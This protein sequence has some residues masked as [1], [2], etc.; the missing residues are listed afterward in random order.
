M[1]RLFIKDAAVVAPEGLLPRAWVLVEDGVI[2]AVSPGECPA[3]GD[4]RL[5]DAGGLTLVPG[6]IDLHIH[7]A[8]GYLFDDGP[9]A[10]QALSVLLP[11]HGVTGFL[12]AVTPCADDTGR[13]AALA[14]AKPKG[15]APVAFFLEGHFL[16]LSGSLSG[17]P[18]KHTAA[19]ARGLMAAAAPLGA[20]FAVSPEL[21][22]IMDILP[23]MTEGGL[24]AFVTHTAAS[25]DETTRAIGLGARHA[26]HFFNVFPYGGDAEPGVRGAGALEAFMAHPTA[27][28]DLI[29]DGEHVDPV[30]AR[31]ALAALGPHRVS[32]ITDAN[33]HA[34]LP[35]G[36]YPGIGGGAVTVAYP[37]GPARLGPE[38]HLPGGLSGSGL[39]MDLAVRNAVSL[40]GLELADAVRMAATNPADV[41]GL[42]GKGRIAPGCDADFSLL[43]GSLGVQACFIGGKPAYSGAGAPA[44]STT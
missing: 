35:P 21:P 44:I 6:F 28:V 29:L 36:T 14:A 17:L 31:M 15:A 43:D 20:V 34:G 11:R 12:P 25:A 1:D 38:S 42:A 39:T 24:P 2:R 33:R 13:L 7:G 22:G 4:A 26:T 8:G 3:P 41:L 9:E 16:T 32:L 5:L 19:Y 30:L 40:L 23:V 18:P 37:G 27:T 10:L